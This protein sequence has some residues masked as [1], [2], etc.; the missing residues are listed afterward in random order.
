MF[1]Q[2]FTEHNII[3]VQI[4]N[5]SQILW[6]NNLLYT[7]VNIF[8]KHKKACNNLQAFILLYVAGFGLIL[9]NKC[10]AIIELGSSM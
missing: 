9:C 3:Y 4:R 6:D 5:Y 2:R 7:V 10:T 1:A 8:F